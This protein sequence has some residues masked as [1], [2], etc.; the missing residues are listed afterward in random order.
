MKPDVVIADR[1]PE[2]IRE[3][4]GGVPHPQAVAVADKR[5]NLKAYF[6]GGPLPCRLV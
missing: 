5:A 1:V 3:R 6:S 2:L 4:A